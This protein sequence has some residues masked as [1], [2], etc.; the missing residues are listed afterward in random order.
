[1]IHAMK[2]QSE[3]RC[4]PY[5]KAMQIVYGETIQ[6]MRYEMFSTTTGTTVAR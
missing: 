6:G 4:H 1:M 2:T 5:L 3:K